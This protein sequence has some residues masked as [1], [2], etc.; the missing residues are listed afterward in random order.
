MVGMTYDDGAQTAL[1]PPP[2]AAIKPG[3]IPLR[4]L[5]LTD[6]FNGALTYARLNP[7]PVLGLTAIAV[8]IAQIIILFIRESAPVIARLD[9]ASAAEVAS[10]YLSAFAVFAVY[11]LANVILSGMLAVVVGRA[12][13]GASIEMGEA[14]KMTGQRVLAL[15]G[16]TL[17]QAGTA[18]ILIGLPLLLIAATGQTIPVLSVLVGFPLLFCT[19][20]L[21]VYLWTMVTFAPAVIVLEQ[22]GILPSIKRSFALVRRSFWRVLGVTL[23]ASLVAQILTFA[24]SWPFQVGGTIIRF[25]T[26]SGAGKLAANAL[27]A[28]GQS[29]GEIVI[30]PFLAGVVVLL[31]TDRRMRAE[32]FDLVLQTGAR[33][34]AT[35]GDVYSTDHLW[36][37]SQP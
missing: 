14:W 7:R 4:P 28:V 3:V 17:L 16:L 8:V 30:L 29:I 11:A 36:R 25:N 15:I 26:D 1:R 24:L 9:H 21:L 23:L 37:I 20:G 34:A 13:F 31:Y 12:V 27:L 6:V 19:F 10:L 18:V 5:I 32:A 35:S 22:R 33:G 2:P